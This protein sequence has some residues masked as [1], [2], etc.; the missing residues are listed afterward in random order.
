M[1]FAFGIVHFDGRPVSRQDMLAAASRIRTA[2]VNRAEY[3]ALAGGT[4]AAIE[5][6]GPVGMGCTP[7]PVGSTMSM[8]APYRHES[9]GV[10][11]TGTFQLYDRSALESALDVAGVRSGTTS[12]EHDAA[13]L[14]EAYLRWGADFPSRVRGDFALALW[15]PRTRTLLLARDHLGCLPFFYARR[16]DSVAFASTMGGVLAVLDRVDDLDPEW[17][18]DLI[19]GD[20]GDP[21]R[22]AYPG[23]RRVRAGH[24]QCERALGSSGHRYWSLQPRQPLAFSDDRDY[25]LAFREKLDEAVRIRLPE[26]P[27]TVGAELSGGLDSSAV[28]AIA[29][30]A[31]REGGSRFVTFTHVLPDALLGVVS[32]YAD[33][34]AWLQ[35]VVS[36]VGIE[37]HVPVDAETYG[38][39]E[40]LRHFIELH[41]APPLAYTSV[42][43]DALYDQA[44]A[45]GAHLLLSGFGGDEGV[46]S[47]ASLVLEGAVARSDWRH[48]LG[49][50]RARGR[51]GAGGSRRS[52]L[53]SLASLALGRTKSRRTIEAGEADA[54]ARLDVLAVRSEYVAHWHLRERALAASRSSAATTAA[55]DT[56]AYERHRISHAGVTERLESFGIAAAAR[57]MQYR[58][59]LLDVPLLE[60]YHAVPDDQKQRAGW[61]RFLFRRSIRG[62]VPESIRWRTDK[63]GATIPHNVGRFRRDASELTELVTRARQRPELAFVDFAAVDRE[64]GR[65]LEAAAGRRDGRGTRRGRFEALL[66]L[67]VYCEMR[68]E[69][70]RP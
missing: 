56:Q 25:E 1:N 15:A 3:A 30:G 70:W 60:Y 39:V 52:L 51:P 16:G 4:L 32:P 50:W 64:L 2:P 5:I 45:H 27:R 19:V 28:A 37:Q 44:A 8:S 29:S 63:T 23:V 61:G 35:Q 22:A 33:E 31:A 67:L 10:V 7:P 38:I 12:P 53:R 41:R 69:G 26:P 21:E 58:Y 54:Q 42:L 49:E 68:A 66:G 18:A 9:S 14:V 62:L 59:P 57:G 6:E 65:L 24:V 11:L 36:H 46:S 34:R 40:S 55:A 17:V 43:S 20:Y 48:I 47:P 13:L